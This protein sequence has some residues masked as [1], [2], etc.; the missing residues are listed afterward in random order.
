[1]ATRGWAET[2]HLAGSH[3]RRSDAGGGK[4]GEWN[5]AGARHVSKLDRG[6]AVSEEAFA[7]RLAHAI[8]H[9]WCIISVTAQMH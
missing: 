5:R 6:P 9:G 8:G 2:Q 4:S 7:A 1:M 3:N